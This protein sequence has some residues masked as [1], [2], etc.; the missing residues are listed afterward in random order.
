LISLIDTS[1]WIDFSR[2]RS[3]QAIKQFTA[4]FI[5]HPDANLAEPVVFEVL[6]HATAAEAKQLAQ[7]FQTMPML[8]TPPNL[9][10]EA[11]ALGQACRQNG[12]TANSLDLL[13]SVIAIQGGAEIVTFDD[14]FQRIASAAPLN[15]RL[16][17]RPAP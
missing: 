17:K 3:P 9:W 10:T 6:R 16:L 5:L 8:P 11:A 14:D 15:L 12:I 1:V 2:A 7:L 4:P 13:I